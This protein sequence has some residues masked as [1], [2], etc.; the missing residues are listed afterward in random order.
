L[1][2]YYG[3][4]EFMNSNPRSN[5]REFKNDKESFIKTAKILF[6]RKDVTLRQQEKIFAHSRLGLKSFQREDYVFPVL[7]FYLNFINSLDNDYYSGIKAQKYTI[8]ELQ[9]KFIKSFNYSYDSDDHRYLIFLEVFLVFYYNNYKSK[10]NIINLL[11]NDAD[12]K[13]LITSK[14][15]NSEGSAEFLLLLRRIADNYNINEFGIDY[16][17]TRIDLLENLKD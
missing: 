14:T 10:K 15:D 1:Y 17:F 7:F 13:L 6:N 12:N 5:N 3:F 9:E 2:D 4:D 8:D 11:F 16:L